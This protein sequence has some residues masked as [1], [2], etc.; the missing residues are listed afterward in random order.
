[1]PSDK[2][3]AEFLFSMLK[4]LDVKH[5]EWK[6]I[7]EEH[8]ITNGHAARMRWCRYRDAREGVK[9]N[10]RKNKR[11]RDSVSSDE[12]S[13]DVR[14]RGKAA[15]KGSGKRKRQR[16]AD[17]EGADD[18]S[19]DEELVVKKE[20]SDRPKKRARIEEPVKKEP[21]EADEDSDMLIGRMKNVKVKTEVKAEKVKD[22]RNEVKAEEIK[23]ER[24]ENRTL[25]DI[26]TVKKER[27]T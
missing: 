16:G 21:P 27:E 26:P 2:Q 19:D 5:I 4:Q 9:P 23:D 10:A 11:G 17:S 20:E 1:M 14:A 12:D 18:K 6:R 15:D 22:D 13:D 3:N 7:A 24:K 25:Y 8:G